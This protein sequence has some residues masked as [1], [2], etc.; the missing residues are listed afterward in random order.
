[1]VQQLINAGTNQIPNPHKLT[2]MN[3]KT[4]K[5][6]S[7]AE[8]WPLCKTNPPELPESNTMKFDLGLAQ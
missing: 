8:G 3:E 5:V 4:S 1:M 7:E 2:L 6:L